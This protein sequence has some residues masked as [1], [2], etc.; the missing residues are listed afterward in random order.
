MVSGCLF[1]LLSEAFRF[2]ET[3]GKPY[4]SMIEL[5]H[6]PDPNSNFFCCVLIK[7][8]TNQ[9]FLSHCVNHTGWL[10]FNQNRLKCRFVAPISGSEESGVLYLF[11]LIYEWN[12]WWTFNMFISLSLKLKF[13]QTSLIRRFSWAWGRPCWSR[14]RSGSDSCFRRQTFFT[15]PSPSQTIS[16]AS[17]CCCA[18]RLEPIRELEADLG[19]VWWRQEGDLLMIDGLRCFLLAHLHVNARTMEHVATV[20][21]SLMSDVWRVCAKTRVPG[22]RGATGNQRRESAPPGNKRYCLKSGLVQEII[23]GET[24]NIQLKII[25][26]PDWN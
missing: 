22:V 16:C 17:W 21:N 19:S 24:G 20:R 14:T 12:C 4:L 25:F 13:G 2:Y 15:P 5:I 18:R 26:K 9:L 10:K 11:Q 23:W 6:S 7:A 8:L 1:Q 3:S